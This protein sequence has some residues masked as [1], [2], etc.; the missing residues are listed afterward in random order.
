MVFDPPRRGERPAAGVAGSERR[1][2]PRSRYSDSLSIAKS[3]VGGGHVWKQQPLNLTPKLSYEDT[4]CIG[5]HVL[6]SLLL[7]GCM[8][9]ATTLLHKQLVSRCK[10]ITQGETKRG[11]TWFAFKEKHFFDRN[12]TFLKGAGYYA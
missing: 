4:L 10:H 2:K 8:K 9:C 3:P 12:S 11:E 6:P 7:L 5:G 1:R